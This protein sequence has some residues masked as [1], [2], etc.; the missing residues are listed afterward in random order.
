MAIP[1]TIIGI[2]RQPLLHEIFLE[3]TFWIEI[4]K[5]RNKT[6]FLPKYLLYYILFKIQRDFPEL[7][8]RETYAG[9]Q[10]GGQCAAFKTESEIL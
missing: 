6:F 8:D 5:K 3:N 2:R 9:I 10:K 4:F 1:I 7:P